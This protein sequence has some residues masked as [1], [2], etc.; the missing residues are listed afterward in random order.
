[1]K[2]A[3]DAW[4]RAVLIAA[5]QHAY[6]TEIA[7]VQDTVNMLQ[8]LGNTGSCGACT[9]LSTAPCYEHACRYLSAGGSCAHPLT[10]VL[11][12]DTPLTGVAN[13]K[14]CNVPLLNP[15]NETIVLGGLGKVLDPAPLPGIGFVCV[16]GIGAE[17]VIGC[18]LTGNPAGSGPFRHL[19]QLLGLEFN[20]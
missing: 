14:L 5:V 16:K 13:F 2:V 20:G 10:P 9:A 15:A 19:P 4:A 18:N 3:T 17:G 12:I 1:E 6:E 7:A 11:N 8:N